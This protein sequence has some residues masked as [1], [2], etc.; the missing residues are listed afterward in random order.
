MNEKEIAEIRRHYRYDR[1]NITRICGC[2]VNKEKEI[3]SEFDQSIGLMSEDDAN[4]MLGLLKK[5]LSGHLGRNLLEIEFTTDQVNN[6]ER[7]AFISSVKASRLQDLTLRN[8]LYNKIIESF[9][10]S[11]SYLII[12]G[13]DEFDVFDAGS[14]EMAERESSSVFSYVICA[15]CPLKE[16]K[17][18]M[19]YYSPEKRFRSVTSDSVLS[20]PEVGFVFP[21]IEDKQTN[22]YK[23]LY[24]TKNLENNYSEL[25]EAL[26]E[27][28]APMPAK[29]QKETFGEILEE[30]MGEDCSLRLVASI[31]AQL[32]QIID[33]AKN[34]GEDDEPP[35]V[36]KS[37]AGDMLRYCGIPE[38]K[39]EAF[40]ESFDNNFGAS[41]EIAPTN[42]SS[43]KQLQIETPEVSVKVNAGAALAVESR[44]IDGIKYILIR[45]DGDVTVNG[46][47]VKI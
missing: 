34:D 6:S 43:T 46:V 14:E 42:L 41:A 8:E 4:G 32:N 5:T 12:L 15:I 47:N 18:Q 27:N 37:N 45:A 38:E 31:H 22:I 16:G 23:A 13:Y 30:S 20:R 44:I 10:F 11:E 40:E 25:V 3:I 1:S 17:T 26:F 7:Y 19:S 33:E 39:V 28:E 2:Q 24:Y 29:I 35:L 9:E 21:V 36:N